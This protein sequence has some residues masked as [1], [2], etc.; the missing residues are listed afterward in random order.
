M[1]V[2]KPST[3]SAGNR[4]MATV[5][6]GY[7]NSEWAYAGLI[8]LVGSLKLHRCARPHTRHIGCRE[9]CQQLPMGRQ[10]LRLVVPPVM[11]QLPLVQPIPAA[12]PAATPASCWC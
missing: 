8:L 10:L 7:R 11:V 4:K 2:H 6:G 5:M 1:V 12:V 9:R 3:S